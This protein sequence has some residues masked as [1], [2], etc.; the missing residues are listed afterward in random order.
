M[1]FDYSGLA[2][3]AVNLIEK[4]GREMVL[5]AKTNV[6]PTNAAR[7]FETAAPTDAEHDIF[8][9][10]VPSAYMKEK[11]VLIEKGVHAGYVAG[12]D[13]PVEITTKD[14]IVDTDG[15]R[16]RVDKATLIQPGP[17]KLV[18]ILRLLE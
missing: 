18:W 12:R 7:P 13:L 10:V 16:Y 2:A 9:V 8:G 1:A 17:D 15:K 6:A 3:V 14:T 5:E 4:F 11:G